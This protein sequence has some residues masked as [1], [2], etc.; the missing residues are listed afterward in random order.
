MSLYTINGIS[1]DKLFHVSSF[2]SSVNFDNFPLLT[3][4]E[5]DI[6][7]NDISGCFFF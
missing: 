5:S 1:L 6:E 2:N 7:K 4:K 3:N